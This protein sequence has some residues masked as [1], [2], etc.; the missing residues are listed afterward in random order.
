[1]RFP[2][3]PGG[4]QHQEV[5]YVTPPVGGYSACVSIFGERVGASIPFSIVSLQYETGV[6]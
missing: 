4:I 6:F 3:E 1:M 5:A 2:L